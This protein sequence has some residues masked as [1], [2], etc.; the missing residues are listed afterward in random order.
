MFS[1]ADLVAI[2]LSAEL[3]ALATAILIVV[4][5]PVA[6]WLA[7]TPSRWKPLFAS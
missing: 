7:R 6:W 3:A 4:G 1:N 2:R 5:T